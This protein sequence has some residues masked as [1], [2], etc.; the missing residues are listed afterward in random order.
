[1]RLVV[2]I[3]CLN[4][5]LTLPAVLNS[6]PTQ[7]AGVDEIVILV[8]DDGSSDRTVEVARRH[9]V[10]QFVRHAGTR[11]L[12]RSFHDGIQRALELGADIVVN[13]DG[14][15][16]YPQER[17]PDLVAPIRDGV[18]DIVI[19]DRQ[20]HQVE[21]FSRRKVLLQRFGSRV[22]NRAA[23]TKVPDAASGFRAYSRDSLMLLNT[24]TRFSY[25]METIIQAGNKRLEIT[26]VPIV[27][28]PKTR[29]SRLFRSSSQHVRMSA[30][31][32][33]RAWIMYRPVTLFA[34]LGTFLG[35]LGLVPFIRWA[36]LQVADTVP[37]GHVQ[38]LLVGAVLLI[39]AFLCVL[40]GVIADL[41]RTNRI[42]IEDTLEHT[43][44]MRFG[45]GPELPQPPLELLQPGSPVSAFDE[46]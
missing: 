33:L 37:G 9:G 10:T 14:D 20:V 19:A 28:N 41:V 1:M 32:I 24:I 43:K 45:R 27:T 5:E 11:G 39:S 2:Q 30:A 36:I 4:E 18:A 16:Q 21:H 15:N 35:L 29:E 34:M 12:G 8:I 25:T 46:A 13:T 22:V 3:P 38:S 7:I 6:I 44:K 31:A 17:I 23:G 26:S 42:L 40:V